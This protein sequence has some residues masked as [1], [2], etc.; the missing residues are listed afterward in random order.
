M[1]VTVA[2][3]LFAAFIVAEL[4]A[5]AS[6][7]MIASVGLILTVLFVGGIAPAFGLVRLARREA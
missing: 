4:L 5:L 3:A 7:M 6:L 2:M 1:T